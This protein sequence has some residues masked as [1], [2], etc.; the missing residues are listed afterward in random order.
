[1]T[2]PH[3]NLV[4]QKYTNPF[5][6]PNLRVFISI[7][8]LFFQH[9]KKCVNKLMHNSFILTQIGVDLLLWPI[10]CAAYSIPAAQGFVFFTTLDT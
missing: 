3:L 1:M 6:Y 5:I 10:A 2:L 8:L 7:C 9:S 4:P